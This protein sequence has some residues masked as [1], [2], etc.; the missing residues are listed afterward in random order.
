MARRSPIPRHVA[1][2]ITM[3]VVWGGAFAQTQTATGSGGTRGAA[4][5]EGSGAGNGTAGGEKSAKGCTCTSVCYEGVVASGNWCFIDESSCPNTFQAPFRDTYTGRGYDSCSPNATP[6]PYTVTAGRSPLPTPTLLFTLPTLSS[7]SSSPSRATST[8]ATAADPTLASS[9]STASPQPLSTPAIIA[10][11]VAGGIALCALILGAVFLLR[12]KALGAGAGS[13]SQD[14]NGRKGGVNERLLRR[15][16]DFQPLTRHPTSPP[17]ISLDIPSPT[18]TH[19]RPLSPHH[20]MVSPIAP[21]PPPAS[22]TSSLDIPEGRANFGSG[23][24]TGSGALGGANGPARAPAPARSWFTPGPRTS[25]RPAPAPAP[26]PASRMF[27]FGLD[28]MST[29]LSRSQTPTL[30]LA[31]P[32]SS[33]FDSPGRTDTLRS[34]DS[35]TVLTAGSV[36]YTFQPPGR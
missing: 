29:R 24:S 19:P 28:R 8:T 31:S 4:G 36:A 12:R 21:L 27:G 17:T 2:S 33:S 14:D 5:N 10:V 16:D 7:P 26:A 11:A 32:V 25:S 34:V 6:T 15:D 22:V 13:G 35:G 18:L 1:V 9:A 20:S 3:S 30:P 23:H